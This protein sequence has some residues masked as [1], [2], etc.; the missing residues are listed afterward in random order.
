[1]Q[2]KVILIAPMAEST[3][4]SQPA[5]VAAENPV[6]PTQ[7]QQAAPAAIREDQIANAVAFLTHPKVQWLHLER[8]QHIHFA[9]PFLKWVVVDLQVRESPTA[10]KRSFLE[11]KGLT[12]AEIDE[13]FRRVPEPTTSTA[14]PLSVPSQNAA[15]GL[16]TYQPLQ[17]GA[18]S[19][20]TMPASSAATT[21]SLQVVPAR[22]GV[23]QQMVPLQ[24]QQ[25]LAQPAPP[26]PIRW[27]Q[28]M[29]GVGVVAAAVYAV[30]TLVVPPAQEWYRQWCEKSKAQREVQE[31]Q[32]AALLEAVESLK[33]CQVGTEGR[34]GCKATSTQGS[35]RTGIQAG[36]AL[37]P[38]FVLQSVACAA[39]NTVLPH[40]P[41]L[42]SDNSSQL[43]RT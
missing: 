25:Q 27:S 8:S 33:A 14:T 9:K 1:M 11:R 7:E 17:Q 3:V 16:I 12:A 18:T 20:A 42:H 41:A 24:Q 32:Q 6:L 39:R 21:S 36:V 19:H 43:H 23:Q 10:T 22:P 40:L 38:P 26:E 37:C 15:T 13:A 35:L 31:R 29:L 34:L 2:H 30:K 28:V 5:E 4:L